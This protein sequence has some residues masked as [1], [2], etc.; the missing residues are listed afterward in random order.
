MA[1]ATAAFKL[2]K[3]VKRVLA[4]MPNKHQRAEVKKL[5]IDAEL[6]QKF[7]PKNTRVKDKSE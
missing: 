1:K 4:V 3:S 2:S 6:T 5:F 7:A